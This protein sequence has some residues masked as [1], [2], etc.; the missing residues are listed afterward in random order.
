MMVDNSQSPVSIIPEDW[1]LIKLGELCEPSKTR[2]N[3]LT[4]AVNYK[5]VELEHLSQETGKLLGYTD[6]SKLKSQKSV[7][8]KNDILFGKLRPYLKKYFFADFNGVCSTEIWVLK[9][10]KEID[11]KWLYY[12]IQSDAVINK[13]NQSTGTKM[14][15]AE[16]K[17]VGD[18]LIPVPTSITEQNAIADALSDIDS[19]IQSLEKLIIKKQAIK[20]GALQELLTGKKRLPGF[21]DSVGYK[22]TELGRIPEDWL[23]TP[24]GE[25][26]DFKNGLNKEKSYFG[27]GTPIVNYMDVFENPAILKS[28]ITGKVTV[29]ED[30]KRNYKVNQGDVF[31]T[32]TSEIVEEIG[33]SSVILEE[34]PNAVFS[35][36]VLR[37]RPKNN[38]LDLNFKK[39]CFR[40]EL[41][42]KQIVSSSSYTTRALTNGR[43]LSKVLLP[44]PPT[45]KEQVNIS[46]ILFDMDAEITSLEN[47]L[48]KYKKVKLGMMQNLLTGRIRLV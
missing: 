41:V 22:Q 14:P 38:L 24:I 2:I 8:E 39:Y 40:S 16:W 5:C 27:K 32:R 23:V 25:L 9:A 26:L 28:D 33:M 46:S 10:K 15:R 42:R 13:A 37:G 44:F 30:E 17:S 4:S 36:F 3:P 34:I 29:T 7:F 21:G 1:K 31:F 19:L 45:I 12:L 20:Q 47:K 11:K 6:S 48:Q 43:L 18:T 35:G